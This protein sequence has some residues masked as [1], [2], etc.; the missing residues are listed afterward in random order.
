MGCRPLAK[1]SGSL[2]LGVSS[3]EVKGNTVTFSGQQSQLPPGTDMTVT[4][5]TSE[6]PVAYQWYLGGVLL[7][8]KTSS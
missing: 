5:T 8:G 1:G 2:V 7:P 4:A 6:N 3:S